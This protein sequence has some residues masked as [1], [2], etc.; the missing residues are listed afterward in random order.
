MWRQVRLGLSTYR[1]SWGFIMKNGLWTFFLYPLIFIIAFAMLSAY[2][3]SYASDTIAPWL[4]DLL[5]IEPMQGDGWW[6]KTVNV[7]ED[8]GKYFVTFIVWISF[9]FIYFKVSKYVVLICLSPVMAFVSE[10]TE[11]VLTGK[12][13]PFNWQQFFKDI[14]RGIMLALR[15]LMIELSIIISLTMINILVGLFI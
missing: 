12:L 5:N 3:I 11:R 2:G 10:K 9:A 7:L 1:R 6:D 14:M 15:N 8:L 4:Y 13:T